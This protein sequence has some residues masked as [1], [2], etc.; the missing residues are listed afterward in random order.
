M[1]PREAAPVRKVVQSST[2][3]HAEKDWAF[4]SLCDDGSMWL[5]QV[6]G[7]E[8]RVYR[9]LLMRRVFQRDLNRHRWKRQPEGDQ[10][11]SEVAN[12]G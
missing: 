7:R 2:M 4:I 10:D 9:R 5:Y 3:V 6:L 8:L 12:G 11:C 1:P